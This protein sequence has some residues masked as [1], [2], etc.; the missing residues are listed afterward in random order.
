MKSSFDV[1]PPHSLPHLVWMEIQCC[2]YKIHVPVYSLPE[3]FDA[4]SS[5]L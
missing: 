4:L 1:P 3:F 5:L 2:K